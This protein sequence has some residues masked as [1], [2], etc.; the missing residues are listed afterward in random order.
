MSKITTNDCK[1][2]LID[3][4]NKHPSIVETIFI[5][6]NDDEM[7]AE[8]TNIKLWKRRNRVRPANSKRGI[9]NYTV[10]TYGTSFDRYAEPSIFNLVKATEVEWE[11]EFYNEAND[12]AYLVIETKAGEIMVADYVVD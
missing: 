6:V 8:L 2:L 1:H 9:V 7:M 5:D 11:R 4:F 3:F 12:V 10:P